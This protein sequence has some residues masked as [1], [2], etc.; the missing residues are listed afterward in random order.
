MNKLILKLVLI[1]LLSQILHL[2]AQDKIVSAMKYKC[3][4][5]ANIVDTIKMQKMYY[6]DNLLLYK[7][8][9]AF[10]GWQKLDSIVFNYDSIGYLCI[11]DYQAK[12]NNDMT[13]I[14]YDLNYKDCTEINHSTKL[15]DKLNLAF[16]YYNDILYCF[17]FKNKT[18]VNKGND[19]LVKFQR[20][21]AP[22]IMTDY[23]VPYNEILLSIKYR[24]NN[25]ILLRDECDFKNYN[26]KREFIYENNYLSEVIVF[27]T[28]KR[29]CKIKRFKEIFSIL[30]L[31]EDD[32]H[33]I[34][35]FVYEK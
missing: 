32:T 8:N 35:S 28:N 16:D 17:G 18:L 31:I 29:S 9:Y 7:I 27:F 11:Y 2:S 1:S 13:L 23:G 21:Y 33:D 4:L 22:S 15:N 26:V 30:E 20:G 24:I 14:G 19:H 6:V 12:Y 10:N 34:W 5:D 3:F 25:N